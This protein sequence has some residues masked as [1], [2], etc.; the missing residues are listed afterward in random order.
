MVPARP[1][2]TRAHRNA[3]LSRNYVE[4][5]VLLRGHVVECIYHDYGNDL[6]MSTF[7]YGQDESFERGTIENGQIYLQL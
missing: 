7:D 4:H 2:R 3:D 1:V 5:L 6:V